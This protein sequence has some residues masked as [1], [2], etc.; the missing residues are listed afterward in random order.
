MD[1]TLKL[2]A[3]PESGQEYICTGAE[4]YIGRSQRCLVRLGSPAISFEHALI[5]RAADDYFVENLSANGTL[6]NNE[7]LLAKTRLRIRDQIRLS[8]DAV[9]RVER[10]PAAAAAGAKRRWLLLGVVAMLVVALVVVIGDFFTT[11]DIRDQVGTYRA[12]QQFTQYELER[13]VIP[14]DIPALLNDAWRLESAGDR[15]S[16]S[17]AWM[18]L[19]LALDA[20]DE[21]QGRIEQ[22]QPPRLLEQ[23]KSGKYDTLTDDEMRTAFKQFVIQME[24]LK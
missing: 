5:T 13:N 24:R 9:L 15:G 18:K 14:R 11:T 23:V 17:K 21:Q 12:F 2:I 7:R 20:W 16:A 3:G 22:W 6:L 19:H 10:L 1:C 8:P 4:T